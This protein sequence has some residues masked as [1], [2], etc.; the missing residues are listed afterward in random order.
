MISAGF[1]VDFWSSAELSNGDDQGG[2]EQAT[3]VE[4]GDQGGHGL[5]EHPAVPV[6]HDLE[7]SVV[8]IPAPVAGIF[9]AFY[10]C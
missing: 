7:I 6:L 10:V 2:V 4:V 8:H 5:I 9:W 1:F 3:L